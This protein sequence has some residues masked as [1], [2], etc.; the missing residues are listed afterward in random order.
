MKTIAEFIPQKPFLVC[1]DSDGC[2]MDTMNIK[3]KTCFGPAFIETYGLQAFAEP[4]Q[5]LWE[6]INLYTKTRGINRFLGLVLAL[7]TIKAQN[8]CPLAQEFDRLKAWTETTSALSNAAL[9][10]EIEKTG[11]N[12]LQLALQW[13]LAVNEKVSA[14]P[15]GNFSYSGV[16]K[17]MEIMAPKADIVVVSS[18][19]GEAL[20]RE[21]TLCGLTDHLSAMAG[22]EQGTKSHVIAQ[23]LKTNAY[24]PEQV[25]MIGDAP[26][27][28]QAAAKNGVLFYPILAGQEDAS[29]EQL[30]QDALDRFFTN[31]YAG[32]YA[33]ARK[34]AFEKNLM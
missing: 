5:S 31:S 30:S 29:W 15:E 13:S 14:L 3:H 32:A 26:G 25:L 8:I 24:A 16:E 1:I 21:W 2:A 19:N 11:D 6:S 18:A 22:Q 4:V 17:A 10:Q 34:D 33:N 12:Q 7:E 27:D 28:L 23:L 20:N 9:K